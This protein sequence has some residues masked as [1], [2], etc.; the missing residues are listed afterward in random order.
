MFIA[1]LRAEAFVVG[2]RLRL[3]S[4]AFVFNETPA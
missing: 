4:I 2:M 1:Y 3:V